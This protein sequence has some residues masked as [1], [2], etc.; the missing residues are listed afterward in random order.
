MATTLMM[1]VGIWMV[2]VFLAAALFS[3][4]FCTRNAPR[5]TRELRDVAGALVGAYWVLRATDGD[6]ILQDNIRGIL[7]VG[8]LLALLQTCVAVAGAYN[9]LILGDRCAPSNS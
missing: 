4:A 5:W 3:R 1:V 8:S 9:A 7:I 6:P 2:A